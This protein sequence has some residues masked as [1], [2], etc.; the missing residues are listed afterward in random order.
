MSV[1]NFSEL[2]QADV[3]P[4]VRDLLIKA[5]EFG[6]VYGKQQ[7]GEDECNVFSTELGNIE[8]YKEWMR[9]QERAEST[10]LKYCEAIVMFFSKFAELSEK[11]LLEY[12]SQ[13]IKSVAPATINFRLCAMLSFAKFRGIAIKVKCVKIHRKITAENVITHTELSA[14]CEG[15]RAA[16]KEKAFWT[17]KFL[18]MTG[19][20]VS[21]FS[22]LS[23][24]GLE[25]GY[26]DLYSKGKVRRI[27]YPKILRDE[28]RDFFKNIAGNYLFPNKYGDR[29]TR[30][31]LAYHLQ[32]WAKKYGIRREV[33]HP[34]SFRHFF[35][36][37][38]VRGGGDLTLLSD[39]LG[40]SDLATTAIYTKRSS[41]EMSQDLSNIM[42]ATLKCA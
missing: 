29:I 24:K 4:Q 6:V 40:H 15:L 39:L 13:N 32:N 42:S 5:F 8:E 14:L 1:S 16:G 31:G 17:V 10:I 33:V 37:E 23:K 34:H 26:E 25:R 7:K 11:T 2:L 41:E 9:R 38:F 3:S 12:K 27:F 35:A 20:R 36:K 28:S 30:R 18:A 22:R 19:A 21:E